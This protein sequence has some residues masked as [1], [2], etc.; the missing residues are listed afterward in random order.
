LDIISIAHQNISSELDE[1]SSLNGFGEE[2]KY[3]DE[4][5]EDVTDLVAHCIRYLLLTVNFETNDEILAKKIDHIFTPSLVFN[6]FG[7]V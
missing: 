3:L 7:L 2:C 5:K 6:P 1:S 4:G